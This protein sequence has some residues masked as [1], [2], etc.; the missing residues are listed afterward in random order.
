MAQTAFAGESGELPVVTHPRHPGAEY[1]TGPGTL[2]ASRE[3]LNA[4][5][6]CGL[7]GRTD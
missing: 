5:A 1:P 2:A 7:H 4:S 6:D 3:P